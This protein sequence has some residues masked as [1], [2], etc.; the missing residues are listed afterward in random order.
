M[1]CL[2]GFL[3]DLEEQRQVNKKEGEEFAKK[4]N[5]VF[6]E[7]SA[8]TAF[9]VEKAFLESAKDIYRKICENKIDINL[10]VT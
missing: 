9:N 3:S 7:T 2:F 10:D 4:H 5:L 1:K 8:K 6:L